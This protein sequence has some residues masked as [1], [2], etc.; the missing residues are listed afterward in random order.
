MH[1]NAFLEKCII[2]GADSLPAMH[3]KC[4]LSFFFVL[5]L[6]L[7]PSLQSTFTELC[8]AAERRKENPNPEEKN[9]STSDFATHLKCIAMHFRIF[10]VYC[11]CYLLSMYY[12]CLLFSFRLFPTPFS[13]QL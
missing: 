3:L 12:T 1:C 6:D 7:I 9:A 2:L 10:P 8:Y 4:I 13:F 11:V 5:L